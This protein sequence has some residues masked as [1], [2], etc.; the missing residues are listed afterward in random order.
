MYNWIDLYLYAANITT[1][2]TQFHFTFRGSKFTFVQFLMK[3]QLVPSHM[4][5]ILQ[6]KC[7]SQIYYTNYK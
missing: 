1:N 4:Y 6:I 3:K 5:S 7:T 2:N